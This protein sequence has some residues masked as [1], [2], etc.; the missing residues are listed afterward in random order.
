VR[1]AVRTAEKPPAAP[2]TR[3]RR[4]AQPP[5]NHEGGEIRER[6]DSFKDR[7]SQA[8]LGA[9][10]EPLPRAPPPT[11]AVPENGAGVSAQSG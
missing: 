11:A 4:G 2:A 1:W 5:I 6:S 8:T 9:G 3:V 10:V 7:C